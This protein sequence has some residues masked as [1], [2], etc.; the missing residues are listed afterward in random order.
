MDLKRIGKKF[1]NDLKLF[2]MEFEKNSNE[3]R[4]E[5]E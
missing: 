2:L 5:C 3:V 4:K 1:E